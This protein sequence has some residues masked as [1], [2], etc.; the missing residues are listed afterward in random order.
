[1]S[2]TH[3]TFHA[4]RNLFWRAGEEEEQEEET[5]R[6][7]R[8]IAAHECIAVSNRAIQVGEQIVVETRVSRAW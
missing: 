2:L 6:G 1:M 7:K 4:E 5:D 3:Q 8:R